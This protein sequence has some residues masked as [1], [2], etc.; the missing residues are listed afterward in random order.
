MQDEAG[1]AR[2]RHLKESA[3]DAHRFRDDARTRLDASC[4]RLALAYATEPR[5]AGAVDA[6]LDQQ[7]IDLEVRMTRAR[8]GAYERLELLP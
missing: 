4:E 8:M 5:R 6:F 1:Q 7:V 3:A 2:L